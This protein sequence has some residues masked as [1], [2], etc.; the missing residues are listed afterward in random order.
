MD[1]NPECKHCGLLKSTVDAT[2]AKCIKTPTGYTNHDFG[3]QLSTSDISI[4]KSH[5]L[6]DIKDNIGGIIMKN[7]RS[8]TGQEWHDICFSPTRDELIEYILSL[9]SD[10][11]QK[12]EKLKVIPNKDQ[13]QE[14]Q[15]FDIAYNAGV[16]DSLN[17]FL[18][19]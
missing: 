19:K 11:Q 4:V 18:K 2:G 13:S 14:R 7:T 1:K 17:L 15:N 10:L 16:D 8:V 6:E 3:I 5:H 12:V 9:L